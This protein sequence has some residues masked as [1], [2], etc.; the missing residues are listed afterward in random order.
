MTRANWDIFTGLDLNDSTWRKNTQFVCL[1]RPNARLALKEKH[2]ERT[3]AKL[4]FDKKLNTCGPKPYPMTILIFSDM[5][6][7]SY[8]VKQ[9]IHSRF[10]AI[11]IDDEPLRGRTACALRRTIACNSEEFFLGTM[12]TYAGLSTAPICSW[13]IVAEDWSAGAIHPNYIIIR[14]SIATFMKST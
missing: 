13:T 6:K 7:A 9:R 10:S 11:C 3:F 8:V 14:T 12:L 2:V 1:K 4:C 5:F